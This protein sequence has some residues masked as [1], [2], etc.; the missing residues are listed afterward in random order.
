MWVAA[1]RPKHNGPWGLPSQWGTSHAERGAGR[2]PRFIS[3]SNEFLSGSV[4]RLAA[5]ETVVELVPVLDGVLVVLPAEVDLAALTRGGKVDQPA[6]EVA[7][8]DSR[9]GDSAEQAPDLKKALADGAT[10]L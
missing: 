10:M 1:E 5:A 6:V 8:D 7:Q 3:G 4:E 9:L 2:A